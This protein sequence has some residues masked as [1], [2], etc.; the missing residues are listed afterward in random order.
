[1]SIEGKRSKCRRRIV[2]KFGTNLITSDHHEL[3]EDII[4]HLAAQVSEVWK[5]GIEVVIATSGAVAAGSLSLSRAKYP[6]DLNF[7]GVVRM[8]ALAAI[9]QPLLM[10]AYNKIFS[11]HEIV[12]AQV[13]LSRDDLQ[14]RVGYLNVRE[15]LTA[16]FGAGVVPIINE[17]DVVAIDEIVGERYGDN[18]RLSAMVANSVDADLLILLGE[19]EGL[20]TADPHYVPGAPLIPEVREITADIQRIAGTSSDEHGSGGMASKMDAARLA[21]ASGIPLVIA[22]GYTSDVIPR[23]CR[24]EKLGTFF[25]A[26]VSRMEARKRWMMTGMEES[27]GSVTVDAGAERALIE[28]YMS[29]LPVGVTHVTGRFDRGDIISITN[30]SRNAVAFGITNYSSSDVSIIKGNNSSAVR[31]L[32]GYDFGPHLVHRNNM[33]MA[34]VANSKG[35]KR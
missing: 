31:K 18:D 4:R 13:L 5:S 17:N 25:P 2:V 11:A 8:Q 30:T 21:T 19:M 22:S 20:H 24:G 16:L 3:D 12:T 29:L 1:M 32:L 23:L 35:Q 10:M 33:V 6:K 34:V 27:H 7:R 15:T 28:R 9:G 26:H 14:S